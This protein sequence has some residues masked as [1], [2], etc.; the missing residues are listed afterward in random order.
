MQ[1]DAEECWSQLLAV[2]SRKVPRVPGIADS[3]SAPVA[4]AS[5]S[6]SSSG[7]IGDNKSAIS[8]L[9]MGTMDSRHDIYHCA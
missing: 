7:A 8:D 9:F 6:S 2:L 4:G 3:S 5:S 1:Q